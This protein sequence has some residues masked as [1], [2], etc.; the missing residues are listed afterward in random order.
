[1]YTGHSPSSTSRR[2]LRHFNQLFNTEKPGR[3]ASFSPTPITPSV[4]YDL[5]A[6]GKGSPTLVIYG[7][8]DWYVPLEGVSAL[9][10]DLSSETTTFQALSKDL[11]NHID[12]LIG[13][14][15]APETVQLVFDHIEKYNL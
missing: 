7:K 15:L 6:I 4:D 13:I 1:M 12:P 14:T 10:N 9:M 3:F 11:A 8:N 5:K 2:N